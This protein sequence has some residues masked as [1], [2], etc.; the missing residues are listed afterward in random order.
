MKTVV[1]QGFLVHMNVTAVNRGDFTE[2]FNVTAYA[3]ITTIGS[4]TVTLTSGNSTTVTFTWNTTGF[5]RGNYTISV[6][7][8]VVEGELNTTNNNFADGTVLVSFVGDVNGDGKVRVD[9]VLDVA[10]RFGTNRGGPPAS[11]GYYYSPNADINDDNKIRTD[12]VLAT[13]QHFGQGP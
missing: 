4:Q 7:A 5:A 1:G 9:D 13:A 3:N 11:T 8:T 10:L 6:N 2:T 12:D